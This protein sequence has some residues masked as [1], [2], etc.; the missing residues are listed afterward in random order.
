MYISRLNIQN[1]RTYRDV[2]FDFKK[3]IPKKPLILVG[4]M[5]GAGK[6][7]FLMALYIGL[8]GRYGLKFVEN[9][10]S[11][12][13]KDDRLF[14]RSALESFRKR[15]A[16][17][18][19][20]MV[21]DITISPTD[22]ER[23]K[24]VK[25][26][27]ILRRWYFNSQ[28]KLR[29][30]SSFEDVQ[31]HENDGFPSKPKHENGED[32]EKIQNLLFKS[33][34]VPA[35][36]FDGEQA[37]S[38]INASGNLQVKD[39]V[40]I[41]FGTSVLYKSQQR[42][43][44]Y[45]DNLNQITGGKKKYDERKDKYVADM[46]NLG[47]VKSKI[48]ELKTEERRLKNSI[49]NLIQEIDQIDNRIIEHGGDNKP[50]MEVIRTELK[51]K[52]DAVKSARNYIH[53]ELGNLALE[54]ALHRYR[55]KIIDRLEMESEREKWDTIRMGTELKLQDVISKALPEPYY[56]DP[57][58]CDLN[59]ESWENLRS[60]FKSAIEGMYNPPPIKCAD[61]F[62]LVFVNN[63]DR[64]NLANKIEK[65][66]DSISSIQHKADEVL[67]NDLTIGQLKSEY[68]MLQ[69]N[70]ENI[71]D[72]VQ[73]LKE[74]NATRIKEELALSTL[75]SALSVQ[76][77]I[78]TKLKSEIDSYRE[79]LKQTKNTKS[80]L[81]V[82]ESTHNLFD[83]WLDQLRPMTMNKIIN[84]TTKKFLNIADSRFKGGHIQLEKS[85]PYE[86]K[87]V[88]VNRTGKLEM[89]ETMAGFERRS[90]GIAYS[91]ALTELTNYRAP[92]VIDTPL[93]NADSEYR[94]RLLQALANA[95]LDQIILLSHDQEITEELHN[96]VL[97]EK[98]TSDDG[99]YFLVEYDES[100]NEST[101]L[102]NHYFY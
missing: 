80:L 71:Q 37:Q 70:S 88:F 79:F 96:K 7:S 31:I 100:L 10:K 18:D 65:P 69:S 41:L 23:L 54:M 36:F 43:K 92:L 56:H 35:F 17:S 78:E 14:Y 64:N 55:D 4:A 51:E 30:S 33:D 57:L 52:S 93:G 9:H 63:K 48:E 20:P 32:H 68:T 49:N 53:S 24:G 5:N 34:V 61:S 38:V 99:T 60:R 98:I 11:Y 66:V 50:R 22:N 16:D 8:F 87:P 76:I 86:V 47:D 102:P 62:L 95:D 97:G 73:E 27:R 45:I 72:V 77:D 101:I 29:Q 75:Q 15:D 74:S 12:K 58:L 42:V 19:E 21:I 13:D 94:E 67:A 91:L 25:E 59:I 40:D 39:A 90:F 44:S 2:T 85:N 6:T 26:V 84:L 82:A 46:K 28:G 1:W 3:P 83:K 89:F 81:Y